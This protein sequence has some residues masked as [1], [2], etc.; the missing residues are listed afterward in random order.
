[1]AKQD[2]SGPDDG[3]TRQRVLSSVLD[4]GPVSASALAKT[5]DL[6]PAAVRRHLDALAEAGL[7]ETRSLAGKRAGRGRP[8]RH[9]VVTAAGHEQISHDYDDLAVDVLEFLRTRAGD[10]ALSA[11][12]SEHT[13]RLRERIAARLAGS[14]TSAKSR[15]GVAERSRRLAAALDEE[16]FAASATPVAVGTPLEAM[17]LCQGHC[18]IQQVAQRFPEFCEAELE[19]FSDFLGVD[20]RRLSTLAGGAHVCTTH[21][22]T[23]ALNRPLIS[24]QTTNEGG[25]R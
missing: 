1:M 25:S 15:T 19:V 11:F 16:G 10:E 2:R 14:P 18:P 9:Y 8:A 7:I 3:R 20:V 21:I 5:M 24:P 12:V 23:S 22:P 17:Q 13:E 6:T 4:Q